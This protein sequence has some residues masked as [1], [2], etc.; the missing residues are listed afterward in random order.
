MLTIE[1]L[2][3]NN[4][5]YIIN[6][7]LCYFSIIL[8]PQTP[9]KIN[10]ESEKYKFA[11]VLHS[12]FNTINMATTST[13]SGILLLLTQMHNYTHL[14]SLYV[15]LTVVTVLYLP[16]YIHTCQ[17]YSVKLGVKN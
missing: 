6:H 7:I 15:Q 5:S 11:F 3:P 9:V 12:F 13:L 17:V 8:Y 10:L 14:I 1:H 16:L 2:V 4:C